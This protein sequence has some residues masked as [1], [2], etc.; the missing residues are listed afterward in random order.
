MSLNALASML[1]Q[2]FDKW[3]SSRRSKTCDLIVEWITQMPLLTLLEHKGD[4]KA[5]YVLLRSSKILKVDVLEKCFTGKGSG[6]KRIQ[7][8]R[9]W[10]QFMQRCVSMVQQS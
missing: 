2:E 5:I 3:S 6:P 8:R 9:H 10:S 4:W 1:K 7:A